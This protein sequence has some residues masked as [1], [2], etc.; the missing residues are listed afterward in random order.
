MGR[1]QVTASGPQRGHWGPSPPSTSPSLLHHAL[2][3]AMPMSK[4]TGPRTAH[5]NLRNCQINLSSFR[6]PQ[7]YCHSEACSHSHPVTHPS[8]TW[9]LYPVAPLPICTG[10]SRPFPGSTGHPGGALEDT[11]VRTVTDKRTEN[12]LSCGNSQG[13]PRTP[14]NTRP[15]K[16]IVSISQRG[17]HSSGTAG[18]VEAPPARRPERA[19]L[20]FYP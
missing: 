3:S 9:P 7:V 19:S 13:S 11:A 5:R 6:V 16:G 18:G 15:Q 10:G 17:G 12:C 8:V 1:N 14:S 20:G 4:G 2:P